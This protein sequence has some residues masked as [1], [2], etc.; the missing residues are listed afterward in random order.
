MLE[1]IT[2]ISKWFAICIL[3]GNLHLGLL[4]AAAL[5]E[6]P[7]IGIPISSSAIDQDRRR[8]RLSDNWRSEIN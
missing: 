2:F 7:I 6:H 3:S 5:T 8:Y 1:R 4:R